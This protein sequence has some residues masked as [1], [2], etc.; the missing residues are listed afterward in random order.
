LARDLILV[1]D[2][3]GQYS[4][5]IARRV[6]ELGV[7]SE[8]IPFDTP[9]SKI[10]AME[11]RGLI[12]SGGPASVYEKEALFP[13]SGIYTLKIPVLGICYGL[14][15]IAKNFSGVVEESS[16]REYGKTPVNLK[17]SSLFEGLPKKT[18]C[19]MSHG[20]RVT[21]LP[22]GFEAIACTKNSSNAAIANPKKKIY[23]LQFHP[24]VTHTPK[25]LEILSN[26]VYKIC[27]CKLSWTMK[28]FVQQ[29]VQ[30]IK[31]KVGGDRV[32]CAIS[33]GVDSTVTALLV[34]K[35]IGKNLTCIFVDHGLLR[36]FESAQVL[37]TLCDSFKL[38]LIH[39]DASERFLN[40]LQKVTDPEKKR[41]IIGEEFIKVFSEETEKL[42]TFKWLAQGTLYPD[43][44]ESA[45]T[46]SKASRI[47]T[48]HNVAG[49]PSWMKFKLI[50]PLR[51][52]YKDEVRQVANLLNLPDEIVKRHPF[53]GPGLAVRI[54][55]AITPEKLFICRE[56][57]AIV[58]EE[59]R[60]AKLYEKVWQ[61]FAFV[62]DD[63]AVGVLGDDRSQGHIVTV[64]VV[65]S[66]DGMTA[67]WTRL[68][69]NLL[70]KISNRITNEVHGVTWV[71]YAIASK[72]PS[73][74]E[75]C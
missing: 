26:F 60:K 66:T 18:V 12:L 71:A 48:H 59:L 49:L 69:D 47:K 44:I 61:A 35:A 32:I 7:Y 10:K 64:R 73:T 54:I 57:S 25:G 20:D 74:I 13:D 34:D 24:E 68:S 4:H 55:G 41:K 46:G 62:G 29:A 11:P 1:L 45:D 53:P 38:N 19:W 37:K 3:G 31:N 28:S 65:E 33:G 51:N 15:L 2:F 21:N 16:K 30:E 70:E 58:E 42:G 22:K 72:P 5:L 14:Q 8:L 40:K 27:Y 63:K 36:K 67:D 6:R 52:L 23:G 39:L 9:L 17:V 56:A 43:V 50:E 75:P